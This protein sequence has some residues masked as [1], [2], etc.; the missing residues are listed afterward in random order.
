MINSSHLLFFSP[1]FLL[2]LVAIAL[3]FWKGAKDG[4]LCALYLAI[5]FATGGH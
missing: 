2:V 4:L 5:Y 3:Y 1:L